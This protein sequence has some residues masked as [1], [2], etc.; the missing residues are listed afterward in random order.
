MADT[1]PDMAALAM[2]YSPNRNFKDLR[3]L[4]MMNKNQQSGVPANEELRT[5]PENRVKA[6]PREVAERAY[7]YYLN[8]GSS[9]GHELEHWFR[10]EQDLMLGQHRTT[11]HGSHN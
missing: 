6:S 1:L 11:F 7:F 8:E 4:I 2:G 3:L 5:T 9:G 10:A